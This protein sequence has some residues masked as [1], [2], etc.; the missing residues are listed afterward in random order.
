MH[1]LVQYS[2]HCD[3]FSL[4]YLLNLESS[5][6]IENIESTYVFAKETLLNIFSSQPTW[7][8]KFYE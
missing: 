4:Q 1:F 2:F 7:S 6:M 8:Y 3:N 5:K